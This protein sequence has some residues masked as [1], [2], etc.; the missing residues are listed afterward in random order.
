MSLIWKGVHGKRPKETAAAETCASREIP[1][2][3]TKSTHHLLGIA[4]CLFRRFT[5]PQ[6]NQGTFLAQF[7]DDQTLDPVVTIILDRHHLTGLV[8]G[9]VA[10]RA[11]G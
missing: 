5:S 3:K 11:Q 6:D 7:A 2:T 8:A 1:G 4:C 10:M 9:L